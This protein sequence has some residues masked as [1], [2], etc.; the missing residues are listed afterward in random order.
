MIEFWT[1]DNQETVL[2]LFDR[3]VQEQEQ[4]REARDQQQQCEEKDTTQ[5]LGV[6][7]PEP[8]LQLGS[9]SALKETDEVKELGKADESVAA[10]AQD[11]LGLWPWLKP[12]D[13]SPLITFLLGEY[14]LLTIAM[15][16]INCSYRNFV[17][18]RCTTITMKS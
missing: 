10:L 8:R 17:G 1:F 7:E 6:P 11:P 2:Q 9:E 5:E 3:N 12:P 15:F 4:A 14:A 16:Y 18:Y 13:W